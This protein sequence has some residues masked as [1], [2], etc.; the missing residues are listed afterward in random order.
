MRTWDR[1][2]IKRGTDMKCDN[3]IS[4]MEVTL[5]GPYPWLER[6]WSAIALMPKDVDVEYVYRCEHG[7]D[8]N[9]V[10]CQE[11]KGE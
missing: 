3:Q 11:T 8:I 10:D 1:Y 2:K 7:E 5:T 4:Y 6:D 9:E